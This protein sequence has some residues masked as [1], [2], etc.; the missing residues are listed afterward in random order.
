MGRWRVPL[1]EFIHITPVRGDGVGHR[2]GVGGQAAVLLA[3]GAELWI[4]GRV[5]DEGDAGHAVVNRLERGMGREEGRGN[6]GQGDKEGGRKGGGRKGGGREE[7][8]HGRGQQGRRRGEEGREAP[9]L[10]RSR[11]LLSGLLWIC[12]GRGWEAG[13]VAFE[14]EG[15]VGRLTCRLSPPVMKW[16]R[17]EPVVWS[18]EVRACRLYGHGSLRVASCWQTGWM[19]EIWVAVMKA[20]EEAPHGARASMA[21]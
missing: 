9:G 3:H 6:K 5:V 7:V 15:P 11:R 4:D 12:V 10:S 18:S 19:C 2:P 14:R 8:R 16:P 1:A 21:A 17:R 13:D 20:T